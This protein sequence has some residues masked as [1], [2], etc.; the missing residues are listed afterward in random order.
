ML[1]FYVVLFPRISKDL[2]KSF[3][4]RTLKTKEPLNKEVTYAMKGGKPHAPSQPR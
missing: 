1:F 2:S 3:I 4:K